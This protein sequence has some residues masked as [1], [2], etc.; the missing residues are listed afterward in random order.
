MLVV[1]E[2]INTSRKQIKKAVAERDRAAILAEAQDQVDAGADLIDIHAASSE[3]DRESDDLSWIIDTVQE[4]LPLVTFCLDST[5]PESL[6]TVM[7]RVQHPPMVNSITAERPA[8]EVMAP[9]LQMQECLVVA[10]CIDDRGIPR[11]AKQVVDNATRLVIDLEDLGIKRDRIYLDPVIQAVGTNTKAALMALEA[12]ETIKR[13]F[14]NVHLI[15]GLSNVSFGLPMRHL[16]N[17]S[18]LS[19]AMK[20]GLDAALI[21]PLDRKLMS[22]LRAAAVLLDQD[23]W[24]QGYTRAFREGILDT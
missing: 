19:L 24:C 9:V 20:A 18:F 22:T 1:G 15:C 13:E 2:R 12:M 21:D 6:S 23:P 17:R 8:F 14:D 5:N 10:L 11:D 4:A 3:K 16:L 7:N